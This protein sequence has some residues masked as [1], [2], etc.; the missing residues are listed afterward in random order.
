[1]RIN[2]NNFWLGDEVSLKASLDEEFK[3]FST[4]NSDI[5]EM[6]IR[7]QTEYV[8]S[9]DEF[10][11]FGYMVSRA[12]NL[13]IVNVSGSLTSKNRSYNR[14]LGMV[15]Y[16]EIRNAV[17]SAIGAEGVE[18]IVLNMDTPGGQASGISE[19]SDFLAEVD[20]R[21]MPIYTYAGTTMA[22]GGYWLGSVGREIYASKLAAIG[23]IGVVTVHASYKDMYEK[24]GIEVT[25]LRAGEFKA[26]GSPYENLDDKARAQIESQM[27]A[28]YDVF[29][30][31]VSGNRETSVQ[32]LK[33]NAAEGRVFMGQ[34]ALSVGLV[35]HITS[36]D[37]AIADISRK[38]RGSNN[39]SSTPSNPSVTITGEID[40]KKKVL[41]EAG[42]AALESGVPKSEL[43]DNPEMFE[44]VDEEAAEQEVSATAEETTSEE[45][46][47][48]EDASDEEPKVEE[49]A[50]KPSVG[51]DLMTLVSQ[52]STLSSEKA[53]LE[54]R[55]QRAEAERD[56]A[57]SNEQ[58]LVKIAAAA[59]NRMNV[60][61]GAAPMKLEGMAAAT[62][63]DQ[64]NRTYSQFNSK[65]KV[66]ATAQVAEEEDLNGPADKSENNSLLS[67]ASRL[68]TQ[69]VS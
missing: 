33:E 43:L 17:F 51:G 36:F 2:G 41:T 61:L 69:K 59:V 42:K 29:L 9:D 32:A 1:M 64:Y 39:F 44:V 12:D 56:D 13:A 30:E 35:D 7:A 15:S 52:I 63:I 62:V 55:L 45:E 8:N 26:L 40:M 14:F 50:A 25:V 54:H 60:A 38:V 48:D 23:S 16:D 58:A 20:S 22:S 66:G 47:S 49:P 19:L 67:A 4:S 31:T 18:G 27:N 65:Y 37:A 24:A 34:E 11:E 68:T 3:I 21:V 46:T 5:Q 10:G 53:S 6:T 57:K 28:I